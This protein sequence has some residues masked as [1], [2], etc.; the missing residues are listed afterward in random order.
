MG[1]P[2][3]LGSLCRPLSA[4]PLGRELDKRY[5]IRQRVAIAVLWVGLALASL[6]AFS[7]HGPLSVLMATAAVLGLRAIQWCGP[8]RIWVALGI[9]RSQLTRGAGHE[10]A[11]D[12]SGT[13]AMLGHTEWD[14]RLLGQ[15]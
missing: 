7:A 15:P 5:D 11:H 14:D 12:L 2:D 13:F 6:L 3:L 10:P 1:N 8:K 9:T 4:V